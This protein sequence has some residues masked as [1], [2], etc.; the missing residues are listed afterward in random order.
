M[1]NG[2]T[3]I[4]NMDGNVFPVRE[5]AL[6][7]PLGASGVL[8]LKGLHT[9]KNHNSLLNQYLCIYT[10]RK[11]MHWDYVKNNYDYWTEIFLNSIQCFFLFSEDSP[12]V[13][14]VLRIL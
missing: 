14:Y 10:F 12:A 1:S 9:E 7:W 13:I 6:L 8:K 4:V 2:L 11:M 3:V 5:S